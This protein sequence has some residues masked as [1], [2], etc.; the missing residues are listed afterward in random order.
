M[1]RVRR[2]RTWGMHSSSLSNR[3]EKHERTALNEFDCKTTAKVIV[4][5]D[6]KAIPGEIFASND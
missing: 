6:A 1:Q 3:S 4:L 5:N 2:S